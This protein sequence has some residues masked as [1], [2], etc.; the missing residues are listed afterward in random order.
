MTFEV[1]HTLAYY[2]KMY[3]LRPQESV[4]LGPG[5]SS[6]IFTA[7]KTQDQVS[8]FASLKRKCLEIGESLS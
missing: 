5:L 2:M 1:V 7:A 8:F 3:S 4:H 6:V